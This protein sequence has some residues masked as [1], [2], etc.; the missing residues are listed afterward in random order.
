M[1]EWSLSQLFKSLHAKIDVELK[2][3]R[4]ALK[5][6]G[7]KGETSETV[8]IGL[9]G[10]YL[11]HRY[12]VC[13]GHV[14]DS[15]GQFSDQ[16]DVII[17][18]RQ[19]SPF[20]FDFMGAKVVPAESVYAVFEAKQS[21]NADYVSYARAKVKSVRDLSRTSLPIPTANGLAN[22][23]EPE[24]I[25][26]GVLTLD[27]DWNPPM[28][29]ALETALTANLSIQDSLDVGCISS[30][31]I[32]SLELEVRNYVYRDSDC[33][34]TLMLLELIKRLQAMA[35]VPMMDIDAYS[36]WLEK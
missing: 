21:L 19:Y 10:T 6:P 32:F 31:G 36:K 22:P 5:H 9:L 17:F 25:L 18:D 20:I 30:A 27:S 4:E 24:R 2:I 3:A 26:G 8:W 35:T 7:T 16:I 34:T 14:V 11:P 15:E 33:A 23:K 12:R 29:N 13:G 1:S 28:G